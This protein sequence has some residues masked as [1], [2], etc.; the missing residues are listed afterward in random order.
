MSKLDNNSVRKIVTSYNKI[1]EAKTSVEAILSKDDSIEIIDQMVQTL[2]SIDQIVKR[3]LTNFIGDSQVGQWAMSQYGIGPVLT[4]GLLSHIDITKANTAGAIWRYAGF[5]PNAS[6]SSKTAYNGELKNICWKIGVNFSKYSN[7]SQCFYGKLYLQDLNRRTENNNSLHPLNSFENSHK[8]A[9]DHIDA[10]ARRFAVKIF[11]SHFH[12]IAYEE[13][14]GIKP[15]RPT[16]ISIDGQEKE[17]LIPN[18]PF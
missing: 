10:Q 11:L 15:D 8:L 2:S 12:A 3:P 4:A 13:H 7:R 14:Y 1:Q 16:H 6:K 5:D 9:E 17:I 18:N